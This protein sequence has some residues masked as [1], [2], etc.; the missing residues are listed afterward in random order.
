MCAEFVVDSCRRAHSE[1]AAL[2]GA[3]LVVDETGDMQR[4]RNENAS[5]QR[6]VERLRASASSTSTSSS[7]A[8]NVVASA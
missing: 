3:P 2:A 8:A 4:L 1:L 5:L 6:Q 7:R